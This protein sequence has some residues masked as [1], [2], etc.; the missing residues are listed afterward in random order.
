[1]QYARVTKSFSG[2]RDGDPRDERHT[3]EFKPGDKIWGD[4]AQVAMDSGTAQT[5][6]DV[7]FN[8]E[9]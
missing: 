9:T 1:M 3:T 6:S 7:E 4:I 8:R 5:I 2:W